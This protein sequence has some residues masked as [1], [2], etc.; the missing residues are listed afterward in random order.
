MKT[1]PRTLINIP[2]LKKIILAIGVFLFAVS[3]DLAESRT[4]TAEPASGAGKLLWHYTYNDILPAQLTTPTFYNNKI[5]LNTNGDDVFAL[6]IN[7]G[8]RLWLHSL[9]K[10]GENMRGP[11]ITSW[12]GKLY[13]G[14]QDGYMKCLDADTGRVIWKFKTTPGKNPYV[15][16]LPLRVRPGKKS[17]IYQ[18]NLI[19]FDMQGSLYSVDAAS[20][21]L[22]WRTDINDL[23]HVDGRHLIRLKKSMAKRAALEIFHSIIDQENLVVAAEWDPFL[24]FSIDLETGKRNW[25]IPYQANDRRMFFHFLLT[26]GSSIIFSMHHGIKDIPVHLVYLDRTTGKI[27]KTI[28]LNKSRLF[29][30]V[31]HKGKLM[32]FESNETGYSNTDSCLTILDPSTGQRIRTEKISKNTFEPV[33]FLNGKKYYSLVPRN[34]TGNIFSDYSET[35]VCEDE[36]TGRI[37][38][39]TPVKISDEQGGGAFFRPRRTGFVIHKGKIFLIKYNHV[40]CIDTGETGQP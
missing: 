28:P 2:F 1:L 37:L 31:L 8:K 7:T 40:F 11:L 34:S 12:E 22:V 3:L 29:E 36:K 18:G 33:I 5:F 35:I 16:Y 13:L 32:L 30:F 15:K 39:K 4:A 23:F 24:V 6:D 9:D 26:H 19:F 27:Q 38:W 17:F 20:G 14:D 10:R 25:M 21:K